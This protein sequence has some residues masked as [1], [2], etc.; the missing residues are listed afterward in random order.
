MITL[1]TLP[2]ATAQEVFEQ[3]ARHL[4]AQKE[5]SICEDELWRDC[6]Y[7]GS[8]GKKCAAG[9]FISDE[10]Y[11]KDFEHQ[12]WSELVEEQKAPSEHHSLIWD[13]QVVHD[14][15][16]VE[17]WK[18]ELIVLGKEWGLNTDFINEL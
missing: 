3:S 10:E 4:L 15:S 6:A 5:K 7:K 11:K 1:K 17:D 8:E 9:C 16:K 18:A 13:L 12:T 2:Q 14:N